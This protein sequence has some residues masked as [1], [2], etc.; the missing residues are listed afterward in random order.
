MDGYG[1]Y[2]ENFA[3]NWLETNY[4]VHF[5]ENYIE[6]L[7]VQDVADFPQ[8]LFGWGLARGRPKRLRRQKELANSGFAA[9]LS[10]ALS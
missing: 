4:I 5:A 10:R 8:T 1:T 2:A 9:S 3:V 6:E 7:T